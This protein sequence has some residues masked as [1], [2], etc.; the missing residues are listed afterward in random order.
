MGLFD[1]I[2]QAV[3]E[4]PGRVSK[5]FLEEAQ[6]AMNQMSETNRRRVLLA[7]LDKRDEVSGKIS[8]MTEDGGLRMAREFQVAGNKLKKS[9]PLEGYPLLLVGLWL[10]TY[11]RPGVDAYEVYDYLACLTVPFRYG[12]PSES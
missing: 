8:N 10:E 7:F 3:A 12:R 4:S 6:Q 9:S 1:S 2:K 5:I 11:Y